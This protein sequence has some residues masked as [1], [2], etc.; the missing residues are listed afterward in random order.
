MKI[1]EI[2]LLKE[3]VVGLEIIVEK[4]KK[5]AVCQKRSEKN[6]TAPSFD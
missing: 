3:E 6:F 4:K 1:Q 5:L 2:K